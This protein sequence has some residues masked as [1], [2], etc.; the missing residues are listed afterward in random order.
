MGIYKYLK[1]FWQDQKKE[2]KP[3]QKERLI[4]WRKQPSVVKVD[5]PTRLDRARSL[6]YKA[7]QGFVLGRI[8]I[9]KGGRRRRAISG[10]RR[11]KKYGL[12]RFSTTLNLRAVSE[13]RINRKF[14][15]LEVLNS[16]FVGHDGKY[17]WYEVIMVDPN[18]PAIV[19]DKDVSWIITQRKRAYR[20]LTAAAKR[21]KQARRKARYK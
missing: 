5:K 16:Y 10:G 9:L 2:L 3:I 13:Q 11:P 6:G 15:N 12:R 4:Q 17:V 18:H 14:P 8:R 1:K 7:K 20:G 21:S 19:K